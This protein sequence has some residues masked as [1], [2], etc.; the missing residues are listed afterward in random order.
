[1]KRSE[2]ILRARLPTKNPARNVSLAGLKADE[3]PD[4]SARKSERFKQVT[5]RRSVDGN[6]WVAGFRDWV[7]EIVAATETD[8]PDVPITL[9]EF[10]DG[11]V[12]GIVVGDDRPSNISR[13]RAAG[14]A[15]HRRR[16]RAAARNRSHSS[17]RLHR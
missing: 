7:R 11:D 2:G 5:K 15:C 10:D 6:V 1:M 13:P 8:R 12:V 17:R 3:Q 14:C 9:D 4:Y 16:S